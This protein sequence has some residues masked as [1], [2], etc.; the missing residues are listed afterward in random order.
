METHRGPPVLLFVDPS[1]APHRRLRVDLRRRGAHVHSATS[2]QE[3]LE[4]VELFPP[5]LIIVAEGM[6]DSEGDDVA[7]LFREFFSPER[8]LV[9]SPG[10]PDA[11]ETAI[12]ERVP[13]LKPPAAASEEARVL[14][15]DDDPLY[16]KAMTRYLSRFGYDVYPFG[17]ADQAMEALEGVHPDLALLDVRMPGTDGIELAR[18]IRD[19]TQGRVP[20]VLLTALSGDEARNAG[21]CAG[22]CFTLSKEGLPDRVVDL[23]DALIGKV[24]DHELALLKLGPKEN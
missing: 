24:D 22:A 21:R 16:L 3:A 20:F 8:V 1:L 12:A 23:V 15:V 19:S 18:R 5:S 9:S 11:L 4:R 17:S 7:G 13:G 10:A 14:C 6:R 2:V